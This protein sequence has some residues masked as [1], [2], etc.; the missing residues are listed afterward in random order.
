MDYKMKENDTPTDL[1][2]LTDFP[3]TVD[4][5]TRFRNEIRR[6]LGMQLFEFKTMDELIFAV[7][8]LIDPV[9][10]DVKTQKSNSKG[11]IAVMKY[12][13]MEK[14]QQRRLKGEPKDENFNFKFFILGLNNAP[15]LEI[16]KLKP[17]V[18]N[19]LNQIN[20]L[21]L[22]YE[23]CK[24]IKQFRRD[25]QLRDKSSTPM[26]HFYWRC[27]EQRQEIL[28]Y[29]FKGMYD[30]AINLSAHFKNTFSI[31]HYA[32]VFTHRPYDFNRNLLGPNYDYWNKD[33][34]SHRIIHFDGIL[35]SEITEYQN[36]YNS[37]K[38]AFYDRLFEL[39]SREDLI[40]EIFSNMEY[41]SGD[42]QF[43]FNQ[44]IGY[45]NKEEWLAF[46]SIALPQIEGLFSEMMEIESLNEKADS[47]SKKVRS[48]RAN[49]YINVRALD[50]YEYVLPEHRNN[51]AHGGILGDIEL[52][53][54]DTI[55]DLN[56]LLHQFSE[57]ENPF[58]KA[59]R[60]LS[61]IN[62]PSLHDIYS[63]GEFFRIVLD[64]KPSDETRL[65]DKIVQMNNSLILPNEESFK[66]MFR[67]HG[68]K[69]DFRKADFESELETLGLKKLNEMDDI[70]KD[71]GRTE[72]IM[73]FKK[74]FLGFLLETEAF[75]ETLELVRKYSGRYLNNNFLLDELKEWGEDE[76]KAMN[77]I[78]RLNQY[79]KS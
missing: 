55:T 39:K 40:E 64:L 11:I 1:I 31:I 43:I 59:S 35:V 29:Y 18:E 70:I 27:L 62:P 38:K 75:Y 44:M 49:S 45:F 48:L 4:G 47:L 56:C 52:L 79:Q 36:L 14:S 26:V 13:K 67:S 68:V 60:Y 7:L 58:I 32:Q 17:Q 23:G 73:E 3:K 78:K 30:W 74:E 41:L 76:K 2:K 24:E 15:Y 65:F 12:F 9:R 46:Y 19:D 71:I 61:L 5:L 69:Y 53:A 10:N 25:N 37:D 16:I 42:R 21:I 33:K 72:I 63:L 54:Y 51:F 20:D 50:Y 28:N 6:S 57:L 8:K 77:H 34:S 22:K 66:E